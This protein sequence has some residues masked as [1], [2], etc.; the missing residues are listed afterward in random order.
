MAAF[1]FSFQ[2]GDDAPVAAAS[3]ANTSQL[4][5]ELYCT[6]ALLC[7]RNRSETEQCF[8]HSSISRL[9]RRRRVCGVGSATP[10]CTHAN[11]LPWKRKQAPFAKKSWIGG[12]KKTTPVLPALKSHPVFNEETFRLFLAV[13]ASMVGCELQVQF[14]FGSIL[15]A[16]HHRRGE[17]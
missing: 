2:K 13:P 7:E 11:Y 15:K 1:S 4:F 16:V 3:L 9:P 14:H 5:L 12:E 10:R 8:T 6:S 17:K